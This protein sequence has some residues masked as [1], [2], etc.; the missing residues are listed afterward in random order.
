M[1]VRTHEHSLMPDRR[2]CNGSDQKGPEYHH[3]GG[4][5]ERMPA[6]PNMII[7]RKLYT[8]TNRFIPCSCPALAGRW[9]NGRIINWCTWM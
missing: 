6:A 7:A 2:A 8:G 3:W 9:S 4:K 1:G 5:I